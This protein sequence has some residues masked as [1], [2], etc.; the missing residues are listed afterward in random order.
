MASEL[1][2]AARRA[3]KLAKVSLSAFI[4]RA[5][6]AHVRNEALGRMVTSDP[7]DIAR[8]LADRGVH[9]DVVRI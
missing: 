6:E 5:T 8:L 9:A 7:R 1:G 4:A 2:A 3:A